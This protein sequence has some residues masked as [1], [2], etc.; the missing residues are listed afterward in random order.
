M[1]AS[2]TVHEIRLATQL[3]VFHFLFH[4]FILFFAQMFNQ[5]SH[6]IT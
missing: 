5:T 3:I 2:Q 4:N 6:M 1:T